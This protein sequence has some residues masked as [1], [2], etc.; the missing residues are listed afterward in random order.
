M[1]GR[2][3]IIHEQQA[4]ISQKEGQEEKDENLQT[5]VS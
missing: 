3:H 1:R 5:G 2:G 4:V